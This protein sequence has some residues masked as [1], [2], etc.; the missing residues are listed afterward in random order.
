MTIHVGRS[1]QTDALGVGDEGLKYGAYRMVSGDD[2]VVLLGHDFDYEPP[3][4]WARRH[5]DRDRARADWDELTREKTTTAWGHPF[6]AFFRR[7]WN[8]PHN[9]LAMAVRY[10]EENARWWPGRF[11]RAIRTGW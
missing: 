1:A 9:T 8:R 10:G 4:P 6:H 5:G 3:E 2:W 7:W 11:T